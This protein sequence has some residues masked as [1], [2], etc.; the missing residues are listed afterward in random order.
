MEAEW[1]GWERDRENMYFL[2]KSSGRIQKRLKTALEKSLINRIERRTNSPVESQKKQRQFMRMKR[3][4]MREKQSK[5]KK[6]I[7]KRKAENLIERRKEK[8]RKKRKKR[9]EKKSIAF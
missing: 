7:R 5:G 2:N 1:K 9:S 6:G 3:E 8:Q 4:E